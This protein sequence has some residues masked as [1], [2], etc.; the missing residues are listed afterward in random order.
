[1]MDAIE[2]L[3]EIVMELGGEPDMDGEQAKWVLGERSRALFQ[4][5][6]M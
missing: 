5:A 6:P 2:C 1:M 3:Q 4:V